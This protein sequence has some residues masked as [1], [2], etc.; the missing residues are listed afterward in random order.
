MQPLVSIMMPA[1]NSGRFIAAAI[2][3]ILQQTYKNWELIIVDDKST[4]DTRKIAEAH[5]QTEPRIRILDGNGIG[6]ANARNKVIDAATG[7]YIMLLDSDDIALPN[8]L[9][10]LLSEALRHK[11]PVVG[12]NL[13]IVDLDLKIKRYSRQ[14]LDNK[15][16]RKGFKRVLNRCTILPQ[17]IL[18]A[19]SLFRQYRYNEIYRT[20]SDWDFI[21]RMGENPAVVFA[22]IQESLYLYRLNEGSLTMTKNRIRYNLLLRYNEI[23]RRS[24]RPEIQS[25]DEFERMISTKWHYR[26]FYGLLLML[27]KIQHRLV[28]GGKQ[29]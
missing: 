16:I 29:A 4:D 3:S 22:N 7:E 9:E 24:Q 26:I 13:A 18:A 6:V 12:S 27:K 11:L 17:T 28:F 20:L 5:A 21:L 1:R 19:T 10:R 8:R 23:N 2:D 15:S 25:L 14:P